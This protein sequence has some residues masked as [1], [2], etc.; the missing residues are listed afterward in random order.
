MRP[1]NP[2]RRGRLSMVIFL[3]LTSLDRLSLYWKYYLPLLQNKLTLWEASCTD[4]SPSVSVPR[5]N[6]KCP[7]THVLFLPME[8]KIKKKVL[9]YHLKHFLLYLLC[10]SRHSSLLL[11]FSNTNFQPV[12]NIVMFRVFRLFKIA[13]NYSFIISSICNIDLQTYNT[14]ATISS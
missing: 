4:P 5:W 13:R 12:H 11:Q 9:V 8:A 2:Y 6:I 10:L 3:V 1:G 14:S 7:L